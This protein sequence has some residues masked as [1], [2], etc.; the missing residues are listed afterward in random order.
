MKRL[1]IP[2][3]IA[4]LAAGCTTDPYTGQ[5]KVSNTAIGG[6]VGAGLGA[7]TGAL[8]G[9]ATGGAKDAR[10]GALIGAGIG[11]LTGG[12][13]G[14]YMDRQE[15]ALRAQLQASGVSV[16]RVGNQIVLNMPSNITFDSDQYAIKPEF[17]GVLN[18]VAAVFREYNQTL[19]D[20][21]GHTDSD[22]SDA[23]NYQLSQ[24]RAQSVASYLGQQGV[25]PRRF[26]VRGF[27]E[28][29]PIAPNSTEAGKA[30]NRRVEI[31][32]TPLEA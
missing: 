15:A 8:I 29:Q 20:V 11:A 9:A 23:Y 12:G 26:Q 17:F 24:N 28:S 3:V 27:G 32:I 25:D 13:I 7:A 2:L 21:Y 4:G 5:Q 10:R 31:R 14:V 19:I 16:T 1:M 18:S 22:G 30:Q 6:G